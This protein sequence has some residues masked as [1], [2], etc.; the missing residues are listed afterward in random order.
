MSIFNNTCHG[1]T[2][3][4]SSVS[5]SLR[6]VINTSLEKETSRRR[7]HRRR[8]WSS[9]SVVMSA[10]NVRFGWVSKFLV[11]KI[12]R[13]RI[14]GVEFRTKKMNASMIAPGESNFRAHIFSPLSERD[15]VC[16]FE[17][18]RDRLCECV[19][20]SVIK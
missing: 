6:Q 9:A 11:S 15:H 8:R 14:L 12:C 3:R 13:R 20:V 5:V 18:E 1:M 7:R 17:R 10:T 16:V 4:R 2:E 19:C